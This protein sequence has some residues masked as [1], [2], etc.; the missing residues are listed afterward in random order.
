MVHHDSFFSENEN[1]GAKTIIPLIV[2]HIT[3]NIWPK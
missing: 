2:N 1:W 3:Y